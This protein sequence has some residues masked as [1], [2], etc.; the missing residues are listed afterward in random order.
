[1]L[2]M[3]VRSTSE[4]RREQV[5]DAAVKEF[6]ANGF[7]ATSTGA[8]AKRAGISQPYI[9]ALFPNKHE[10]FL[11]VHR[12]VVDRI[13][14][15]FLEAARGGADPQERLTSMGHAYVELLA[16]RDEILVQMQAHAAAGDP[17]LREPVR[18]EFLRLTEDVRRM[19]GASDEDVVAFMSKGMLLNVVAA[20]ELPDGF[21]P[22]SE[23]ASA[24]GS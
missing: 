15:A 21:V 24:S 9:Y 4:E 13:R 17:A 14:R 12:H 22:I 7:H 1:M 16:D 18:Q 11:A 8:I 23:E 10:L 19:S 5:V 3:V 2:G 6:A 20:L